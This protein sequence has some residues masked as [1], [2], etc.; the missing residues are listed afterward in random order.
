V[1]LMDRASLRVPRVGAG[2]FHKVPTL[3]KNSARFTARCGLRKTTRLQ[4]L[5]AIN[6]RADKPTIEVPPTD[7]ERE[8]IWAYLKSRACARA[9][10][11][12]RL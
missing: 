10:Y 9:N 11:E 6:G 12:G 5:K 4:T 7:E 1:L 2:S 8:S 3:L